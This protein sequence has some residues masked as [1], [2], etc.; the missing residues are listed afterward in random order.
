[1]TSKKAPRLTA[2]AMVVLSL[3]GALMFVAK[4]FMAPLPN[5]E[6]VSLLVMIYASI[7]GPLALYPIYIY[8][9]LECLVWGIN[10]WTINYLYIWLILAALAWFFRR[11]ESPLGW[12]II[13]GAFGLAFGALCAIVYVFVGG[14]SFALTW[15]TSGIPFDVFH[16]GGN[17]A[18]ALIL[19]KPCR[20][21]LTK[22]SRQIGLIP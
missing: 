19:F 21:V 9:G 2:K 1:M 15:W 18:M 12:A 8:V 10:L 20:K 6:P 5:I 11:M 22:L 16:C 14:W 13:S 7:Y 3:L 4:M 17:F